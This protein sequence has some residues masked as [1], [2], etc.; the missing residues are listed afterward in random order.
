MLKT[1]AKFKTYLVMGKC[2]LSWNQNFAYV[3]FQFY[4]KYGNNMN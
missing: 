4:Q 2:Q 3:K 1:I